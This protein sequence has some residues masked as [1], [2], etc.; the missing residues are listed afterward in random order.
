MK[1]EINEETANDKALQD[2]LTRLVNTIK[3]TK[4]PYEDFREKNKK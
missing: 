2:V 1:K 4:N 3:N